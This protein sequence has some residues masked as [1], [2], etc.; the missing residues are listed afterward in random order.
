MKQYTVE[1]TIE[2]MYDIEADSLQEAEDKAREE[3]EDRYVGMGGIYINVE[4][5]LEE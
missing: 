3:A 4:E 2:D 1:I 5:R